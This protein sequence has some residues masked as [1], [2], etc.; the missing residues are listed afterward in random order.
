MNPDLHLLN[1][2]LNNLNTDTKTDF[3]FTALTQL[4]EPCLK[5]AAFGSILLTMNPSTGHEKDYY[6]TLEF[7][8][9][10]SVIRT[11]PVLN[12]EPES[13]ILKPI[14][15]PLN[16][17]FYS[18]AFK[19]PVGPCIVELFNDYS[20]SYWRSLPLE[21]AVKAIPGRL[22]FK[23]STNDHN[24]LMLQTNTHPVDVNNKTITVK[25]SIKL[26][27]VSLCSYCHERC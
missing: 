17:P 6:N 24:E 2:T 26:K 16:S 1:R 27:H 25:T 9:E 10:I 22:L 8:K 23:F 21:Y 15:L 14:S 20:M 3:T 4:L 18:V 19:R 7:Y 11:N 12:Y 13:V 5:G